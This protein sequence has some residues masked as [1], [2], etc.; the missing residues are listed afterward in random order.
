[1]DGNTNGNVMI[2]RIERTLGLM[3]ESIGAMPYVYD[4]HAPTCCDT[5]DASPQS[6]PNDSDCIDNQ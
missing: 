4:C 2:L 6:F 3:R 5:F 1:M